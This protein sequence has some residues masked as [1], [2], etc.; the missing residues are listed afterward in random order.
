MYRCRTWWCSRNK[1]EQ[2][3]LK[4][5]DQV[6]PETIKVALG[7]SSGDASEVSPVSSTRAATPDNAVKEGIYIKSTNGSTPWS[8][9]V[10]NQV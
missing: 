8:F 6:K 9:S 4:T 3:F 1:T 5:Y 2:E 10:V 7:G